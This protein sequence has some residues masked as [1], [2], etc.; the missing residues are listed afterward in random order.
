MDETPEQ[1]A[2]ELTIAIAKQASAGMFDFQAAYALILDRLAPYAASVA[3]AQR[4]RDAEYLER[5]AEHMDQG[6]PG[7]PARWMARIFR[8]EAETLRNSDLP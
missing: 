2:K 6:E 1:I 8:D 4:E 5:R 7:S 3:Q